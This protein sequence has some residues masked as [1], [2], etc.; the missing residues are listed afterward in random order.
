M[1]WS[2]VNINTLSKQFLPTFFR[3]AQAV[4]HNEAYLSPLQTLVDETLYQM[5]HDGRNIYLEKVLNEHFE[6]SGYD[7]NDHENTKTVYIEDADTEQD[8]YVHLDNEDPVEFLNDADDDE[9]DIFIETENE[10]PFAYA[11]IVWIPEAYEFEEVKLRAFIDI[12]RYI[13]KRYIIQTY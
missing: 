3:K 5:Q 10:T 12:Y 8:I 4:A 1:F 7:P 2:T 9:E 11:F 13:G 6:V